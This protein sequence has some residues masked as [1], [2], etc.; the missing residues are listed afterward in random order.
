MLGGAWA[1]RD[2]SLTW[3]SPATLHTRT[4]HPQL[5][6]LG[7]FSDGSQVTQEPT[8]RQNQCLCHRELGLVETDRR[9]P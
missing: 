5:E 6:T 7:S 9:T 4:V 3:Q 8:L 1:H 2:K